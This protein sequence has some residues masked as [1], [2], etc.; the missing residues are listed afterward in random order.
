MNSN[1]LLDFGSLF[2]RIKTRLAARE[3]DGL[4]CKQGFYK[5]CFVLKLQKPHWTNDPMDQV[6]NH[7]GIFFSVWIDE[8]AARSHRASYNIH[9]FKLRELRGHSIGSRDFADAF[10]K[11]FAAMRKAWPN[12]STDYGP[13][14][15]MEGWIEFRPDQCE[16]AILALLERFSHTAPLIDRLLESRRKL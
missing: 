14:T 16:I 7:S 12:V 1:S 15:L 9:A 2:A 10:R 11:S 13:Q 4:I 6:H 5:N 8:K 3:S